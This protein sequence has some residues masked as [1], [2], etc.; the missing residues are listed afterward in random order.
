MI[1]KQYLGDGVYV[2]VD[3]RDAWS[4]RAL[5][6]CYRVLR[7]VSPTV[8][9]EQREMML[10]ILLRQLNEQLCTCLRKRDFEAGELY[11]DKFE[12][13]LRHGIDTLNKEHHV[14]P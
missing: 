5:E 4:N 8:S 12:I 7:S 10:R 3:R 11:I 13:A 1:R 6:I 9:H 14:D 2:D